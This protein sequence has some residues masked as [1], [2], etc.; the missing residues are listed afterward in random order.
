MEGEG[1]QPVGDEAVDV[2]VL[3]RRAAGGGTEAGG[4]DAIVE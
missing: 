2:E 4:I 3:E 1:R